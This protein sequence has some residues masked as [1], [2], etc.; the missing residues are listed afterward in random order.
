M[1]GRMEL[2]SLLSLRSMWCAAR[3]GLV[4]DG[5]RGAARPSAFCAALFAALLFLL[6]PASAWAV[7][8]NITDVRILDNQRTAEDTVRS[9]A[10]INVGDTLEGDTLEKVRERLNTAGLFSDVNVWWEAFGDGVRV[11]IAVKDKFPW[12]PVPT[13]SWSANNRSL[14]VVF[15]HGN[16]F[17]RGKQMVLGGRLADVDSG[18]VLA[19]RDPALF[20]SWIY[21]QLQGV[22]QKQVVP[23][24]DN[25]FDNPG[26][27]IRE[28]HFTSY[29]FEG[30]LGI[31]WLR[32]VR[33]QVAWAMQKVDVAGSDIPATDTTAEMPTVPAAKSA[34]VGI[35]RASLSFDFRAREFAVMTGSA[36]SGWL[37][38]GSSSFGSDVKYW[39]VG[40]GFERG[41]KFFRAHNLIFSASSNIGHNLPFWNEFTAGGP[42]LRGYLFQ[43]YRGDTQIS[44]K[45]EYHFPLFSVG[46][47]DFRALG[48]YDSSALW[49]R[50]IPQRDPLSQY[51]IRDTPDARS[52]DAKTEAGFSP[53]RD[54]HNAVGGG[55]RFFLRSVAVPLVGFDAGYG[56]EARQWRFFLVLGA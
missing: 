48:F 5:A 37:D 46:S 13:A 18:A 29:G 30:A 25:S 28:T 42:N 8:E 22:V 2:T 41:I 52:F 33:T 53:S 10:G 7:G 44:G 39:R 55:L 12:A 49:F 15:V 45:L 43:Q 17:G 23:E 31:A 19:Y 38:V 21:W 34:V 11:N 6:V 3:H 24:Y 4:R 40:A 14:G 36:L 35:G 56:I 50:E 16:L 51:T 32:R 20:G 26:S 47:L 54:I 9:L 1:L 27:P